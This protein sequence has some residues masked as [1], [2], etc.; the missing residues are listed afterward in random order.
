MTKQYQE[1]NING[2]PSALSLTLTAPTIAPVA[3]APPNDSAIFFPTAV[4]ESAIVGTGLSVTGTAATGSLFEFSQPGLF[5][6]AFQA[7]DAGLSGSPF[8][9]LRGAAIGTFGVPLY[10]SPNFVGFP[11]PGIIGLGF[12]SMPGDVLGATFTAEVFTRITDADLVDPAVG[13]NPDRQVVFTTVGPV[14]AALLP[15]TAIQVSITRV[16]R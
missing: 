16:S 7:A 1:E 11:S 6:V 3:A 5:R 14:I 15:I 8:N 4:A 9:I 2:Q 13:V 12:T 10:P